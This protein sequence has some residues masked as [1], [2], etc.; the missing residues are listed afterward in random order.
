MKPF[1]FSGLFAAAVAAALWL[2][3][4]SGEPRGDRA[5]LEPTRQ[6]PAPPAVHGLNVSRESAAETPAPA[7][8]DHHSLSGWRQRLTDLRA[9][10]PDAAEANEQLAAE[11]DH[12][13]HAWLQ[14]EIRTLAELPPRD[15]HDRLADLEQSVM[16]GAAAIVEHLAIPGAPPTTVLADSLE[17]LAAEIQYAEMAP[18]PEARLALLRLDQERQ[19]RLTAW[20]AAGVVAGASDAAG[21]GAPPEV[22]AWYDQEIA[23][24]V[25]M[26]PE[27]AHPHGE[28][29][30]AVAR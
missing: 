30:S 14:G 18:T 4:D 1:L 29:F 10:Q 28:G 24:I 25:A 6:R 23:A 17:V 26:A 7:P 15:R 5:A 22:E 8:P 16:E 11:I 9:A 13:Y 3:S 12:R 2:R 19:A 20:A 21:P 27:L